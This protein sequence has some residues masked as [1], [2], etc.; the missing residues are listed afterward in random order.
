MATIEKDQDMLVKAMGYNHQV[1]AFACVTTHLVKEL[2]ERHQTLA[3]PIIALGQTATIGAM[4]GAM[5]KNAKERLGIQVK[6]GGPVGTISVQTNERL[7]VRGYISNP[8][9]DWPADEDGN[10]DV[11]GAI[12]NQGFLHVIR[13]LGLK[14]PYQGSVPV[15]T[16]NLGDDFTYYFAKSEQTPSAVGVAVKVDREQQVVRAGGFVLQMMP[17][18]EPAVVDMVEKTVLSIP[19]VMHLLEEHKTPQKILEQL[20]DETI[21]VL[22]EKPISFHCDCSRERLL[23]VLISLGKKELQSMI[24][25]KENAEINCQFCNENY[26][27][28]PNELQGLLDSIS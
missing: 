18:A 24:D 27:F 4:M 7:E 11:A 17:F 19:S 1:R 26:I 12:G 15:M 10:L 23:E 8:R 16:G 21:D 9:L 25:D 28:P 5:L 13:D 20:L 3:A 6:G 22:E 14:E 2:H